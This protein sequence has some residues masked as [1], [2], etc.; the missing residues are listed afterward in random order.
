[1][2]KAQL[3]QLALTG[4][5]GQLAHLVFKALQDRKVF[6]ELMEAKVRRAIKGH[7]VR[8]AQLERKAPQE[9]KALLAYKDQPAQLGRKAHLARQVLLAPLGQL[10]R[11]AHLAQLVYK[12]T[13]AIKVKQVR[14]AQPA[15]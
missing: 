11:K 3:A 10:V 9:R 14:Q 4:L 13:K 7:K 1:M 6:P 12:A 15:P 2:F 8:P 5:Q